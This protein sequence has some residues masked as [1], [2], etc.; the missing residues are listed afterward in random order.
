M[1]W[2]GDSGPLVEGVSRSG[3]DIYFSA[4]TQYTPDALDGYKRL[5]DAR[6]GGG[7]EFPVPPPPCP[8][9]VCQGTPKGAP[10]EQEPGSANFAGNGNKAPAARHHK[11]AHKKAHHK[12]AHRKA[13]HKRARHRAG[14]NG[15]SGR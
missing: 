8:L 11:K 4:A 15:R 1:D 13:H 7:F 3:H 5:Y 9:E 12:K 14:H 10:D 6:I 2:F